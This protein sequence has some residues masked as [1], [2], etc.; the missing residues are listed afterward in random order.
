MHQI[1]PEIIQKKQEETLNP[2]ETCHKI[3]AKEKDE[4]EISDERVNV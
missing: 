2:P 4:C 3:F 1:I